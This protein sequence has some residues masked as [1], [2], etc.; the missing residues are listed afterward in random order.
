MVSTTLALYCFL[1]AGIYLLVISILLEFLGKS[2]GLMRGMSPDLLEKSTAGVFIMNFLIEFLF[3]VVIPTLGF[4]F[5][6]LILPYGGVKSGVA[7][8]LFAFILGGVPLSMSIS[9]RVKLPM[10]FLLYTLL[11]YLLKIAGALALIG[12]IYA[13]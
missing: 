4:S 9:V 3:F 2:L 11:S 7:A 5:F 8:A 13:L 10:P 12:Y 6:Y 1:A